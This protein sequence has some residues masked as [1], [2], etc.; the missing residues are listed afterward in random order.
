MV[1]QGPRAAWRGR[2]TAFPRTPRGIVAKPAMGLPLSTIPLHPDTTRLAP[3]GWTTR[4][5][6]RATEARRTA[7]VI[8]VERRR[9]ARDLHDV[10]GQ[11]MVAVRQSL[12]RELAEINDAAAH[13][14]LTASLGVVDDAIRDVRGMLAELRPALVDDL[15]LFGAV[16]CYVSLRAAAAGLDA[17]VEVDGVED[18]IDDLAA[19]TCFRIVQE[20]VANAFRHAA[21][22][23]V[24]VRLLVRGGALVVEVID[25][26][27]GFDHSAWRRSKPSEGHLGLR[28]MHE[29]AVAAGGTTTLFT[30][31]G[32]GTMIRS[33]LPIGGVRARARVP[34]R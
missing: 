13:A 4:A 18:D 9:L 19:T 29:R 7:T 24:T 15:G 27:Q 30:R 25:D 32:A 28:S 12:E 6:E 22:R 17:A 16:D 2:G 26:G 5:M 33:I 3:A 20:A 10:V 34:Q 21:A 14:R 31:P 23:R 8:E 1:V 11:A